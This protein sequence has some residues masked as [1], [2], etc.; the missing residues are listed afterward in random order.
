MSLTS[1]ALQMDPNYP[2]DRLSIYASESGCSLVLTQ[3]SHLKRAE[4]VANGNSYLIVKD[5]VADVEK[6]ETYDL[7][8]VTSNVTNESTCLV[9]F[10]SG[11]TGK[12]KGV[13]HAHR[14]LQD[15]ILGTIT[16]HSLCTL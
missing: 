7:N 16:Y 3:T 5:I 2:D 13:Q 15:L 10:T 9:L 4:H 8:R 11:S 1:D 6:D 12:P 14:H